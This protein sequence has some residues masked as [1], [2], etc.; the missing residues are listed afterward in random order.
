ML[1]MST[2]RL[3]TTRRRARVHAAGAR[4]ARPVLDQAALARWIADG[5]AVGQTRTRTGALTRNAQSP[6]HGPTAE[7][8]CDSRICRRCDDGRPGHYFRGPCAGAGSTSLIVGIVVAAAARAAWDR[9]SSRAR[10]AGADLP[11]G[12][13]TNVD[14]IIAAGATDTGVARRGRR[15]PTSRSLHRTPW[16]RVSGHGS[17]AGR[18][19]T[20]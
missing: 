16:R 2:H 17:E 4:R 18:R 8:T 19:W 14:A 13:T 10:R 11:F 6:L 20:S 15:R 5:H 1:T 7:C 3:S 9:S 12:R